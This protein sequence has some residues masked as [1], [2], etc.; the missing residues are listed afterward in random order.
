MKTAG[1]LKITTPTDCEV[2]ISRVFDAP[3][4]L[5]YQALTKPELIQRW[6]SGQGGWSLECNMDFK[7]GG[8]WR[9]VWRGP[10]GAEMAMRG[11]YSKIVPN[12]RIENT[13]ILEYGCGA[14]PGNESPESQ[15][16]WV[17]TEKD[18]KT[19]LTCTGLYPSKEIRDSVIASGMEEGIAVS[20]DRLD[21]LL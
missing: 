7:V 11:V 9:Y 5:V 21:D 12:E 13:E 3:K 6:Y 14:W 2:V 15:V 10:N 8:A 16:A 19:T 20:Y 4:R 18:G 17:F 1:T